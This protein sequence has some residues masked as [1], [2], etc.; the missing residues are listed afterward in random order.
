M[1]LRQL[2]HSLATDEAARSEFLADPL[3]ALALSGFEG[4][5]EELLGTALVHHA[6]TAPVDHLDALVP[7]LDRFAPLPDHPRSTQQTAGPEDQIDADVD[8]GLLFD[9]LGPADPTSGPTATEPVEDPAPPTTSSSDRIDQ[10][11]DDASDHASDHASDGDFGTGAIPVTAM[12]S[13]RP[14]PPTPEAEPD[15]EPGWSSEPDT[16]ISPI[17]LPPPL[18]DTQDGDG[19]PPGRSGADAPIDDDAFDALD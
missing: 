7:L 13:P 2:L 19:L 11:R 3:S 10:V 4:L 15:A 17:D 12:G 5:D 18:S 9:D 8:P 1:S 6:D 14:V 16:I